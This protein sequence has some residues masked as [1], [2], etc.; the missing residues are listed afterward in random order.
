MLNLKTGTAWAAAS[1]RKKRH[2]KT[3]VLSKRTQAS[4][5]LRVCRT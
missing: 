4:A 2:K 3:E 5:S 1:W